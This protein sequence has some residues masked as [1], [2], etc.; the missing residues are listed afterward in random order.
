MFKFDSDLYLKYIKYKYIYNSNA[1]RFKIKFYI[2]RR[3][4]F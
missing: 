2:I 1:Y 4:T 3:R